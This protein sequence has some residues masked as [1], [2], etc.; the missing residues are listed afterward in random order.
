M[1]FETGRSNLFQTITTRK[2]KLLTTKIVR[3]DDTCDDMSVSTDNSSI[4]KFD[5]DLMW[6]EAELLSFIVRLVHICATL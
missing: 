5:K 3:D 6:S 2:Q 4:I 1:I